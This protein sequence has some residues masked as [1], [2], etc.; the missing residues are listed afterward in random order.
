MQSNEFSFFLDA[1]RRGDI[2]DVAKVCGLLPELINEQDAKGFCPLIIEAYNNHPGVVGIL[3][4][5]GADPDL[6]DVSGNTALMGA[7]FKGYADICRQLINAGAGVNIR[8]AQGAP[9][10]TF[11]A[12][13]GQLE[14]A[15]LLL[16]HGADID[17]GD[18]RGK[19]AVDHAMIQENEAMVNLLLGARK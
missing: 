1:C 15:T 2:T 4:E 19:S 11:A 7:A 3:L 5:H 16:Q 14:I 17:I 10:L 12:T 6:Q 9:A 8:N 18:S 13:F